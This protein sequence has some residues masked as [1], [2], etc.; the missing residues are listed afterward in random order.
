[1]N[2]RRPILLFEDKLGISSGYESYWQMMLVKA[3]LSSTDVYRRS[4]F[5]S[6]GHRVQLLT[7][8]GN[9][10]A[11]G[12]NPDKKVQ[13]VLTRWTKD[14]I[15]LLKPRICLCM[16]PALLFLF[17]PDWDQATLDNLR[18]GHYKLHGV[19]TVVM[20]GMSAWYANKREKDIARLN[21]GFTDKAEWEEE[22]GGDETDSDDL[23]NMWLEPLS[24]PYGRFTLQMDLN[25]ASRILKRI[26]GTTK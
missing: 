6:L 18:G 7:T 8:S 10:K 12:F 5:G 15:E 1:M 24:I 23:N 22:H 4:T 2:Q 14:Q 26:E 17:N 21:D 3:G 20:F 11:P 25:K 16:D 9:R 19:H 13:E